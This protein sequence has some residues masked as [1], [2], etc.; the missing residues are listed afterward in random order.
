MYICLNLQ[1]EREIFHT[2]SQHSFVRKYRVTTFSKAGSKDVAPQQHKQQQNIVALL[3][4]PMH[5]QCGSI[6]PITLHLDLYRTL[7]Q[8]GWKSQICHKLLAS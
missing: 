5:R 6:P 1:L 4:P 8:V 3:V 7:P 2:L